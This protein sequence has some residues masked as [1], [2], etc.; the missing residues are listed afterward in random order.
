[1]KTLLSSLRKH[2]DILLISAGKLVLGVIYIWFG[3]IK[4]VEQSPATPLVEALFNKTLAWL[5]PFSSFYQLFSA[6]EVVIGVLFLCSIFSNSQKLLV[7]ITV[8]FFGHMLTTALPLLLLGK[9]VW[10]AFLVPTLEGQ[11][12]LKNLALGM[13]WFTVLRL[14][15]F[16]AK[17]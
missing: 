12:I 3:V 8:I 14:S 16:L 15:S 13:L 1:M 17:R 5:L 7:F 9:E 10:Q 11:Y 6:A 4:L 2:S